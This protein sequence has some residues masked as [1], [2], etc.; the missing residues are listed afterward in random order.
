MQSTS[1]DFQIEV[2]EQSRTVPVLVDFWASWCAPCRMLAPIL[3]RLADK[4]EGRWKLVK[5]NTEEYP[6]LARDYAVRSIPSVKLFSDGRVVDE[7]SGALSEYQ[8]EQWLKNALPSPWAA[9]LA[10]AEKANAAGDRETARALLEEVLAH[11]PSNVGAAAALSKLLLFSDPAGARKL[12]ETIE[13]EPGQSDLCEIVRTIAPMIERPDADLPEG[14]QRDAYAS[15]IAALRNRDFD[16]AL[17]RF[18]G[19]LRQERQYDQDGSRKACIAI[20]RLLGEDHEIT[21]KYRRA[22]DRAF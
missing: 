1:F 6:E 22:F 11:E 5:V 8:V 17:D 2:L 14:V 13:G 10:E 19:V 18:I 21:M 9:T 3:E 4:A 16:A 20:F 15:A 12:A 7:F